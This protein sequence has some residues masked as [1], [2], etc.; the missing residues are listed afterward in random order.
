[1]GGPPLPPPPPPPFRFCLYQFAHRRLTAVQWRDALARWYLAACLEKYKKNRSGARASFRRKKAKGKGGLSHGTQIEVDQV[2]SA[3]SKA[4]GD[5][6][7][8]RA[9]L[10]DLKQIGQGNFGVV[11]LGRARGIIATEPET[12][13]AVKTLSS[14]D[15][16]AEAEFMAEVPLPPLLPLS[17]L[18]ESCPPGLWQILLCRRKAAL[19]PARSAF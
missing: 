8:D 4:D 10:F 12:A 1:M 19:T 18:L 7:F 14:T 5:W 15:K 3:K 6:E 11:Y 2:G 13:V 16:A 17:P 9:E